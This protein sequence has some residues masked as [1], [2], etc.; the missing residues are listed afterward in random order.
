MKTK[1]FLLTL[2]SLATLFF[3]TGLHAQ[4]THTIT[5]NVNTG[6]IQKP[7]AD[8]SCDFGQ[9]ADVANRDFT[10]TVNVGDTVIWEGVSSDAPGTDVVNIVSINHEGG[11]NVFDRN[12]LNGDGGNPERVIAVVENGNAGQEQKYAISFTVMND[13]RKRNGVFRIDPKFIIRR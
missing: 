8:E 1:N 6:E 10:I 3:V 7:Y 9:P 12:I 4:E 5:L 11:T 2:A 13:G